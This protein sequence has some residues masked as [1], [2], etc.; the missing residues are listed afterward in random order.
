V[1]PLNFT[2][3]FREGK[4]VPDDVQFSFEDP[5]PSAE[6]RARYEALTEAQ[7]LQIDALLVRHA[8][9]TWQKMARIVASAM[10]ELPPELADVSH[11]YFTGRLRHFVTVGQLE[12]RGNFSVMRYCELRLRSSSGR[13]T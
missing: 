6:E 5:P 8:S 11:S 9:D 10:N 13:E 7:R 12:A 4:A 3:R 1:R 2:V